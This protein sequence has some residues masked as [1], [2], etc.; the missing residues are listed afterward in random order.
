MKPKPERNFPVSVWPLSADRPPETSALYDGIW[1]LI[2]NH[3][4]WI[5]FVPRFIDRVDG[6][7]P[8]LPEDID[9]PKDRIEARLITL[10]MASYSVTVSDERHGTEELLPSVDPE[11]DQPNVV[12]YVGGDEFAELCAE[13]ADL[14]AQ[15]TSAWQSFRVSSLQGLKLARFI[16]SRFLASPYIDAHTREILGR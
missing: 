16:E 11:F 9:A 10:A 6:W 14:A 7:P 5:Y 8:C 1:R 3:T 13:L 2:L 4:V 12:F 15:L